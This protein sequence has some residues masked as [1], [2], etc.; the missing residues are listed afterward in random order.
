MEEMVDI[1]VMSD[2]V[3]V[4]DTIG[5]TLLEARLISCIQTIG[6]VKSTYWWKGKI[7]RAEEWMGILKSR[8]KLY[9]R[10][11]EEILRLH[12]YETPQIQALGVAD[13]LPSYLEWVIQETKGV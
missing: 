9:P 13:V 6:P 7:E 2:S 10:I 1:L 4:L 11:Q 5:A 8:R 3:E 12:P